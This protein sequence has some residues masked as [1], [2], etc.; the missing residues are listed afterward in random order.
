M[1]GGLTDELLS[2]TTL[3]GHDLVAN[4]M[5]SVV[6]AKFSEMMQGKGAVRAALK[7]V[8]SE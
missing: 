2:D 5:A 1:A 6:R 3:F 4:G 7:K 8:L